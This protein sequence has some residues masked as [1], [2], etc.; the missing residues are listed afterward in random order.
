MNTRSLTYWFE[1][2]RIT[3]AK[4]FTTA[5]PGTWRAANVKLPFY[6]S[7]VTNAQIPG[8]E[9]AA[10]VAFHR[11]N[12]EEYNLQHTVVTQLALGQYLKSMGVKNVLGHGDTYHHGPYCLIE[13]TGTERT[14]LK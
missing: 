2:Y 6:R 7:V 1:L 12:V 11:H 13:Y 10:Y 8:K 5:L 14:N 3:L 4:H 9:T